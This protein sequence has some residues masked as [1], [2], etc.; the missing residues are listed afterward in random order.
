MKPTFAFDG[1]EAFGLFMKNWENTQEEKLDPVHFS[2]RFALV[3]MD[4]NM[5]KLNGIEATR[6]I[7]QYQKDRNGQLTPLIMI[8]SNCGAELKTLGR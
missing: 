3:T 1:A 7:T 4:I 2:D 8:T 6:H 5:S